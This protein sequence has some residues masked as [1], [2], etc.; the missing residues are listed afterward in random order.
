MAAREKIWELARWPGKPHRSLRAPTI[1][2]ILEV[3]DVGKT[4]AGE[5]AALPLLLDLSLEQNPLV[6]KPSLEPYSLPTDELGQ[7]VHV[8]A[9]PRRLV[10]DEN[11][12]E[13]PYEEDME[14]WGL[15]DVTKRDRER[16]TLP[17]IRAL[18]RVAKATVTDGGF[19]ELA[20]R[21][22]ALLVTA[23]RL[24]LARAVNA[25]VPAA[26]FFPEM[27]SVVRLLNSSV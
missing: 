13:L 2:R 1:Q 26:M 10:L 8:S 7:L 24:L 25:D 12:G 15:A 4:A 9:L 22:K 17:E 6:G 11:A 14:V 23:D 21:K 20:R 18:G 5:R 3:A 27:P 16:G 19:L